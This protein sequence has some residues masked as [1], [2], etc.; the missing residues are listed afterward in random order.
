VTFN[1]YSV[2]SRGSFVPFGIYIVP[3]HLDLQVS[4]WSFLA[5]KPSARS[6]FA[7]EGRECAHMTYVYW[8]LASRYEEIV[9]NVCKGYRVTH[10]KVQGSSCR[11]VTVRF[12]ICRFGT[13]NIKDSSIAMRSPFRTLPKVH[14]SNGFE[15]KKHCVKRKKSKNT[16]SKLRTVYT[17]N[18]SRTRAACLEG[19]HDNRFTI[20]VTSD[21]C[22]RLDYKIKSTQSGIRI[23]TSLSYSQVHP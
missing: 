16:P 6:M 12:M 9:R 21:F 18:G 2:L 3:F 20:G 11:P 10:L 15:K 17:P 19:K 8:R 13:L 7:F 4:N 1:W 5:G 23:D 14:S 22:Y